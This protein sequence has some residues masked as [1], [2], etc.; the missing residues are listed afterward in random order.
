MVPFGVKS[1]YEDAQRLPLLPSPEHSGQWRLS[2]ASRRKGLLSQGLGR[3][4]SS[5]RRVVATTGH[6]VAYFRH[7]STLGCWLSSAHS[8]RLLLESH[9]RSPLPALGS[10]RRFQCASRFGTR[11]AEN[12]RTCP[13]ERF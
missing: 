1:L 5:C 2:I 10:I 12:Y 3:P 8:R 4:T 13:L 6:I 9:R 11:R 7:D